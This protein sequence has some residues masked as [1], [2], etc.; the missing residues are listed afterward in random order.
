[1]FTKGDNAVRGYEGGADSSLPRA[2]FAEA[3]SACVSTQQV[4][5][6]I[7]TGV[8]EE[9]ENSDL[10]E[11]E[12]SCCKYDK[13]IRKVH[14]HTHT[15]ILAYMLIDLCSS[16]LCLCLLSYF[17][18]IC[19]CCLYTLWVGSNGYKFTFSHLADAFI[20]SDLQCIHILH[21]H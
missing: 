9:Q 1:M 7:R 16:C 21:L 17:I 6:Q 5:D 11:E 10:D 19:C 3:M 2:L 14:T 15:R 12:V 4:V 8:Q 20:Q 13:C 18:L